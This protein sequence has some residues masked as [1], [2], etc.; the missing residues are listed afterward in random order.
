MRQ[1][2][3]RLMLGLLVVA[4]PAVAQDAGR[5][6]GTEAIHG[7]ALKDTP[8]ATDVLARY[9]KAVG[10]E[11]AIR[12]H[13]SRTAHGT[14]SLAAQGIEGKI[15]LYAAVPDRYYLQIDIPGLG[16]TR[17]GYDGTVAWIDQPMMGPMLLEGESLAQMRDEADY[18]ELIYDPSEYSTLENVGPAQIQGHDC[19][20]I[21]LVRP[22]GFEEYEYFD[23][24][25]G[26]VA[27]REGEQ[28][29][30]LGTV[31]V[32]TLI[33]R[34]REFDGVLY[35]TDMEQELMGMTQVMSFTDVTFDDVPDSVF[36]LPRE[37]QALVDAEADT[38]GKK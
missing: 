33:T 38:S 32:L 20:K 24:N 10:G 15:L 13:K 26:L 27:A 36:V 8:P 35:P 9:M 37:I 2:V 22:S 4:A 12:K 28:E 23:Q 5:Q 17:T 1:W 31:N 14:F 16:L 21:H 7:M 3:V 18:Y 25:T 29:S 6:T 34:H 19:W 11:E 30:P